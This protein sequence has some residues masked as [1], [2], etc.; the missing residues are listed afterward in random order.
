MSRKRFPLKSTP[1][2]EPLDIIVSDV[3]GYIQTETLGKKRYFITFIDVNTKYCEVRFMRNKSEAAQEAI[4]F[5]EKIK[6]QFGKKCKIFRSDRG[7]EYLNEKL[8]GFLQKEGIVSQCTVGYCPEQ[9]GIAERKNRTLVEAA[10]TLMHEANLPEKFWAEA[11][12]SANYTINRLI[13]RD[14]DKSPYELMYNMKPRWTELKVF[15]CEGFVMVP[16]EKRRKLDD[17]AV[18]MKF[19]GYDEQAKGYRMTDGL[20]VIVSREVKFLENKPTKNIEIIQKSSSQQTKVDQNNTISEESENDSDD[21]NNFDII[22]IQEQQIEVQPQIQEDDDVQEEQQEENQERE[23]ESEAESE[24]SENFESAEE[25]ED[26]GPRRSGRVNQGVPPQR[27]NDYAMGIYVDNTRDPETYEE[28][29]KSINAKEWNAAMNEEIE[30]IEKNETWE[31]VEKPINKNIVGSKWVFKTKLED[32]KI[33]RKARVVAKGFTQRHGIDYLDVFAPVARGVTLRLLLSVA[34][35]R[36]MKLKQYDVKTAFLNGKLNE[37]IYM[38]PPPGYNIE[39]GKV[40]HL[41]KSLYGLK[42]AARV[43]NQMI[44]ETLVN[45]GCEQNE[46]DNCLYSFTSG[47]EVIHLL[48]HVDDILAAT[49]NENLLV[50]LMKAIG[51]DFEVKCVGDV[52]E[53]LG[54]E[55]HRD[56]DGNIEI[57]QEK[58]IDSI[59]NAAGM[60]NAKPSRYP[61]DT[62]YYKLEGKPLN[63][64][65]IYRKLI[66]MLLYISTNSRPDIAASVAILSQKVCS[67][68]SVDMNEVKRIIRYLIHTKNHTL[69]L[70]TSDGKEELITYSDANWG[71]DKNDGKSNGGYF[72]SYNGGTIAWCSR[73]QEIVAMSTAEAEYVAITE[74]VKEAIWIKNVL[75]QFRRRIE[76]PLKIFTDNQSAISIVSNQR[77]NNRTKHIDLKYHFVRDYANKGIIE[78]QYVPSEFNIADMMTK[79][80]GGSKIQ[81]LRE[82]GNLKKPSE[83]SNRGG[84]LKLEVNDSTSLTDRQV[85]ALF[86]EC[87]LQI[88]STC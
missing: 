16:K 26:P 43:W 52:K 64:N 36:Q 22:D 75:T 8:Q 10:R 85:K 30:S 74:A 19:V 78:L 69:K 35:K 29:T 55:I 53:Y 1:A 86:D 15:G 87:F 63:S 80:L 14:A 13:R 70:S 5:I 66:G 20:K 62:G 7:L 3:C 73:K 37:E 57:C 33:K 88:I 60:E 47:G 46:T 27:Y 45:N 2:N 40:C 38:K 18:K 84:V 76:T 6:T 49:T 32:G 51:K 11:I 12:N 44:H 42:Q 39:Q 4:N 83:M 31:I 24:E 48:I 82:L 34:G 41:K 9:N 71:E 77:F 72:V 81:Q 68:R 79:P 56:A 28:A 23:G 67:P 17:K 59:I 61:V 54:I 50:K 65:E 25:E 21:D 58:F